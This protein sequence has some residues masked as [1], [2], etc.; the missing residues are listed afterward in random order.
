[1]NASAPIL[2]DGAFTCVASVQLAYW[3]LWG[4]SLALSV[5]LVVL[6]WTRWGHSRP[7]HKCAALS[8]SCI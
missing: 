5:T 1:M 2:V 8:L 7:L 4:G 6:L 3:L